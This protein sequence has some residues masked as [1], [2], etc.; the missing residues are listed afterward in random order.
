VVI[1]KFYIKIKKASFGKFCKTALLAGQGFYISTTHEFHL[2]NLYKKLGFPVVKCVAYGEKLLFN[3]PVEGFII[4][5]AVVGEEYTVL[6]K[7]SPC[8]V[9]RTLIS[10]YGILSARLHLKGLISSIVRVTDLVCTRYSENFHKVKFVIIDREKGPLEIESITFTKVTDSLASI[11]V[12]H[13]IYCGEM[14]NEYFTMF[15]DS[16]FKELGEDKL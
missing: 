11:L 14:K 1:R 12:R 5:E 15:F 13:L 2:F 8:M 6:F 7:K 10:A 16:Y 9:Q 3:A 4:Q